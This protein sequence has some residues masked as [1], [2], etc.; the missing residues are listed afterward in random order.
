MWQEA[1]DRLGKLICRWRYGHLLSAYLDSELSGRAA[2]AVGG[3]LSTCA[4]CR[5]EFEQLRF[6]NRA[7]TALELLPTRNSTVGAHVFR[8]AA[9][10]EVSAVKRFYSQKIAVPLPVLAGLSIILV[11]AFL[12]AI[13]QNKQPS[14]QSGA[15]LSAPASVVIKVVEVPVERVVT[16]TVYVT[17]P[18]SSGVRGTPG[19]NRFTTT[20]TDSQEIVAHNNSTVVQWS[21]STLKDFRPAASANLRLVKEPER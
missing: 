10:K 16:R 14:I 5:V 19:K 13:V 11:G 17:K 15:S 20:P 7:L 12:L 8:L 1:F 6:A 2:K 9:L 4:H 21:N 18:R 3:H